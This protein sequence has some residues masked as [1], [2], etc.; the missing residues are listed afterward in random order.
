M[1]VVI[2]NTVI[3]IQEKIIGMGILVADRLVSET[4]FSRLGHDDSMTESTSLPMTSSRRLSHIQRPAHN[5]DT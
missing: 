5:A 3:R 2:I 4:N 1:F